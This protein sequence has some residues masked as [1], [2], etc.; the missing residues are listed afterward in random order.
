M[1]PFWQIFL[2]FDNWFYL[3][4]KLCQFL[5]VFNHFYQYLPKFDED[6]LSGQFWAIL[7]QFFIHVLSGKMTNFLQK[8]FLLKLR[9]TQLWRG[10]GRP[11][12]ILFFLTCAGIEDDHKFYIT[13]QKI[14]GLRP[15]AEY[16]NLNVGWS[17]CPFHQWIDDGRMMWWMEDWWELN[18]NPLPLATALW[19]QMMI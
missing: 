17:V 13:V 7:W 15:N 10:L 9:M 11:R 5:L 2:I 1:A 6:P 16:R 8:T 12:P 19:E 4:T 14:S 18:G 3:S